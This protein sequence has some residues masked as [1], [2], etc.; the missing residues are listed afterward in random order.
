MLPLTLP[1]SLAVLTGLLGFLAGAVIQQDSTYRNL[2]SSMES[3]PYIFQSR[4]RIFQALRLVVHPLQATDNDSFDSIDYAAVERPEGEHPIRRLSGDSES[5]FANYIKWFQANMNTVTMFFTF[6]SGNE[7]VAEP[8][9]THVAT[10]MKYGFPGLDDIHV[11]RNFVLS[12]DRRNRIAHW[13]CEHLE[14]EC[15]SN[16]DSDTMPIPTDYVVD[17]QIPV[18]FRAAHRDYKNTDWVATQMASPLNYCC[19]EQ[20]YVETFIMPNIA[21]LNNGLKTRIWSRLEDY[22]RELAVKCGSV[23]VYTGPL[24]MPQRITFRNWAI[25]HQVIGMNTVAVPTHFFKVIIAECKD[26]EFLP[27]MEGYVVP[28]TEIENNVELSAFMSNI[29]DIE[30]FAGLK[31]YDGELRQELHHNVARNVKRNEKE[32]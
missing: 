29:R 6:S 7:P 12:Y 2:Q 23:Y 10:L 31:F 26:Q 27:Y 1:I 15:L 8:E 28:N 17:S 3:D 14:S 18:I 22:V 11:Y 13:V 4:Q 5:V 30:H 20:K 21:P 19:D 24:F 25:R 32:H 9:P 16:P